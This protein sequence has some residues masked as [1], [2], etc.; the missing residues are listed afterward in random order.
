MITKGETYDLVSFPSTASF[1]EDTSPLQPSSRRSAKRVFGAKA[2]FCCCM[3]R[4]AAELLALSYS[5][6]GNLLVQAASIFWQ[7]FN[8][9]VGAHSFRENQK[10]IKIEVSRSSFENGL[11]S[12]QRVKRD[13]IC[14]SAS[15]VTSGIGSQVSPGSCQRELNCC[16]NV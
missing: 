13:F 11:Y 16:A 5:S 10:R 8:L 9:V 1:L 15:H 7:V 3:V 14:S 12:E 6:N 2:L 4:N